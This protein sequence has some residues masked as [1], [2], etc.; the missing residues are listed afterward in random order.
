MS[1]AK[2]VQRNALFLSK[3][4]CDCPPRS[5]KWGAL[6]GFFLWSKINMRLTTRAGRSRGSNGFQ[7]NFVVHEEEFK[8]QTRT[9]RSPGRK[10]NIIIFTRSSGKFGG[11][12]TAIT[13]AERKTTSGGHTLVKPR[14]QAFSWMLTVTL[15]WHLRMKKWT[16]VAQLL[17][18]CVGN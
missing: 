11:F 10:G 15:C 1:T 8:S 2:K 14:A 6:L 5:Y 9:A 16:V 18:L 7:R 12:L 3:L 4:W 17:R 13:D